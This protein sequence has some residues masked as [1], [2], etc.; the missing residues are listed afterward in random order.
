MQRLYRVG[1]NGGMYTGF[2]ITSSV[3]LKKSVKICDDMV[4]LLTSVL[5]TPMQVHQTKVFIHAIY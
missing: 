5:T 3:K 2:G 4:R 1:Y